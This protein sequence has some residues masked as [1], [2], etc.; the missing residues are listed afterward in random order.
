M[1]GSGYWVWGRKDAFPG[2]DGSTIQQSGSPNAETIAIYGADGILLSEGGT[3]FRKVNI[4]ASG[5]INGGTSQIYAVKHPLT[6]IYNADEPHD[7]YTYA[8]NHNDALW[9]D[10]A[11]KSTYDPCPNGWRVPPDAEKTFGD[12]S[13]D[14]FSYY[15][16]GELIAT[17]DMNM[18]NGR[19][20]LN[21]S[22]YPAGG[23][24]HR[25]AGKLNSIGGNGYV[26]TSMPSSV[27]EFYAKNFMFTMTGQG[28]PSTARSYGFPVRCVQE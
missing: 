19:N 7:W 24:R 23:Y 11:E 10:G 14:N 1:Y 8:G 27:V 25:N 17:G 9:G 4:T 13:A 12:F 22:W 28:F 16:E 20:Y 18:T 2:A 6:L 3:G 21:V 5:V 26:W 15:I